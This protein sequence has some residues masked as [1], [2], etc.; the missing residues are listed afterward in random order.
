[1]VNVTCVPFSFIM[2]NQKVEVIALGLHKDEFKE[3]FRK[4]TE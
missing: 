2:E 3:K 1:M 4:I